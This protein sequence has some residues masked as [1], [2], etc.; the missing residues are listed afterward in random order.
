MTSAEGDEC[1]DEAATTKDGRRPLRPSPVRRPD[2]NL[3]W[4]EEE[5]AFQ[6]EASRRPPPASE[7]L[8]NDT[9]T[10]AR[11]KHD[12]VFMI[13]MFAISS[14]WLLWDSDESRA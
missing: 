13:A 4:E 5:L 8:A 14:S 3:R 7:G 6:A 11:M 10:M 1:S 2:P 9:A 12:G